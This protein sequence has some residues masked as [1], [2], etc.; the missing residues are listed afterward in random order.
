MKKKILIIAG[1]VV[2]LVVVV[3]AIVAANLD[4]IINSRKG[5]LLAQAK[6]VTGRDISIGEVGVALWPGIG[7]RVADVVVGEDPA[8]A[9]EPFVTAKDIR[10]NVKFMPLLKKQVEV[11][12]FVLNDATITVI[13]LD[14][15]RFNFT[16]LIEKMAAAAPPG[17]DGR[18]ATA[19]NKKAA[20]ALAVA[21]IENGT[22]RY[23]DRVTGQDRT[24]RDIDFEGRDVSLDS[25]MKAKVAAAVFSDEQD[26]RVEAKLGPLGADTSP[27]GLTKAPLS[28]SLTLEPTTFAALSSFAPPK[29]GTPKSAPPEGEMGATAKLSGTIGAA[30]IDE[31]KIDVTA[32]G[33]SEPNVAVSMSGGPFNLVAESTLVFVDARMKGDLKAENI[34]LAGVKVAPPKDPKQPKPV[35]GGDVS[36]NATFNGAM[37]A[38]AFNGDVDATDASYEIPAQFKKEAGVPAKATFQGTFVPKGLPDDGITFSKIDVVLHSLTAKGSGIFVPFKGRETMDF[39]FEGKTALAPWKDLL[40]AMAAMSPSGD[41]KV[42]LRV[43]GKPKPGTKP[44]IR[45]TAALSNF[46]AKL[47]NM[48]NPLRNGAATVSFTANSASIPKATFAIGKSEFNV[49]A[50]VPS[51][52]PMQATYTVTSPQIARADVQAPAPNA[53]PL[54]RPEVFRD[55]VVKGQA[56][57]KA[58][59]VVENALTITSKSGIASNIDYTDAEAVVRSTP[60]KSII[61]RFSAKAMG[62]SLSGSG[63]FEPK[64]SKFDVSTKVEKVNLAEYFRFKAPLLADVL[65][66]RID[67]DLDL[68]GQGKTWEELQKTL[69]GKGG[70]LV[71]EGAFLNVNLA[72]QLFTSVQKMPMVPAGFADRIKAKNPK[73]FAENKTTFENLAGKLVIADG[74]IN[75]NDLHLKNSDF[76]LTGGGWFSFGKQMDLNTSLVL[77]EKLT[78]DLVAEVPMAKYLLNSSG[79]FE[80]PIKL[81]GAIAKPSVGVDANLIQSRLQQGLTQQGKE[82]LNKKATDTVKGLLDGLGKKK[83]PPP[84]APPKTEPAPAPPDSTKP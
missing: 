36:A 27:A 12:R 18:P 50:D 63:T 45:G 48:P 21:D 17:K 22:V 68:G 5:A 3:V 69:V 20:F 15:K 43:S 54:P 57:E 19:S 53:K 6:Q 62:G 79:R 47:P 65:V 11:K 34:P 24:I 51:L 71:I 81:S 84:P 80:L 55:V 78:G 28:A 52:K 30:M 70:A 14:P 40:P 10:V 61:D 44:D 42:T 31:A 4:K 13:K 8:V 39:S 64:I 67:A 60:E 46:G 35:M 2:A 58:P 16:S 49:S 29:P 33:A 73:L 72:Q 75:S 66:G 26:V 59:K 56:V 74:K 82:E 76:S 9:T 38:L 37:G 41:A 32:L 83:A 77:S 7:V 1:V 23:V 25:E